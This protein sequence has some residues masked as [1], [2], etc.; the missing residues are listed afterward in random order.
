MGYCGGGEV[1]VVA[2]R[3]ELGVGLDV[4]RELDW[5]GQLAKCN[6]GMEA[7]LYLLLLLRTPSECAC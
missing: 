2:H 7:Y 3:V 1:N 6:R 4:F 5:S